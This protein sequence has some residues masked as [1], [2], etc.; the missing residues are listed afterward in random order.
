MFNRW[1]TAAHIRLGKRGEAIAATYLR[2]L[3][4]RVL[5]RNARI[6]RRDE[7]DLLAQDP[8]DDVLVFTE[9][10]TRRG[11]D[12]DYTPSLNATME[13]RRRMARAAR[14]WA[15]SHDYGGGYRLDIVCVAAGRVV[16]HYKDVA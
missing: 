15:A 12:D 8:I 7:I 2:R 10:K 14:R 6:G 5:Q 16:D 9:V 3:G 13:K 11:E 4:Y 1:R